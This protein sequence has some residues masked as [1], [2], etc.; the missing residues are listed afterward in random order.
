VNFK[1]ADLGVM[2][3]KY[4]PY[5][6]KDGFYKL[7]DGEEFYLIANPAVGLWSVKKNVHKI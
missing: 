4:N 1:Y 2:L 5:L 7:A 3:N 6:L